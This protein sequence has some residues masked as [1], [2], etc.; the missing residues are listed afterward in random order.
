MV[1]A[2][3]Y[4]LPR[5]HRSKQDLTLLTATHAAI[6][7]FLGIL[8]VDRQPS[9][10]ARKLASIKSFYRYLI[11]ERKLDSNPAKLMKSPKLPRNLPR[12]HPVD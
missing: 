10:R 11:R 6:R 8:S 3:R 1:A 9:T 7:C 5:P 2:A 4:R 12:L